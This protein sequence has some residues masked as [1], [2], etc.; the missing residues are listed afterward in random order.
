MLISKNFATF[1]FATFFFW[2]FA[3]FCFAA[4]PHFLGFL[5]TPVCNIK[6]CKTTLLLHFAIFAKDSIIQNRQNL[7]LW[8]LEGVGEVITAILRKV[9]ENQGIIY[10]II[11]ISTFWALTVM[12]LYF[13]IINTRTVLCIRKSK[14]RVNH[15]D[16]ATKIYLFIDLLRNI[17]HILDSRY[18]LTKSTSSI[19]SLFH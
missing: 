19:L 12:A 11:S 17:F 6:C 5:A 16:A 15:I 3:T 13:K 9:S 1:V 7:Y 8:G 2:I 14:I 4:Y 10:I 18:R